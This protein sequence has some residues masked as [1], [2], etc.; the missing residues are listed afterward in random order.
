MTLLSSRNA[1]SEDFD[2]VIAALR[3][4]QV[5][6]AALNTHALTLTEVPERFATLLD[7]AEGV[8]KALVHVA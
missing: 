2:T 4:G 3:A 8:V 5:P 6:T 1:T 7:P